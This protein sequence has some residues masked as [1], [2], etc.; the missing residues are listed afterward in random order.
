MNNL[1]NYKN[2]GMGYV[3]EVLNG[4][5]YK[6]GGVCNHQCWSETMVLQPA[7]EGM[8]GLKPDAVNN[9]ITIA[10]TFPVNWD[11]VQVKNIKCGSKILAFTMKRENG[12]TVWNFTN[13]NGKQK[14]L[15]KTIFPAGTNI[16]NTY[17][18][19]KKTIPAVYD[20][21]RKTVLSLEANISN[22]LTIEI[23]HQGGIA[24]LPIITEPKPFATSDGFRIVDSKL[25]NNTFYLDVEGKPLTSH[26][27][28][29]YLP[30][31]S[32]SNVENGKV[33]S[34][35]GL[36]TTIQ[37]D[38]EESKEKYLYKQVKVFF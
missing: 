16:I 15:F 30:N 35:D 26:Q 32:I 5:D 21:N 36:Y 27:I 8:L 6:P 29:V 34:I 7:I 38:F 28:I 19:G 23:E 2:F 33:I 9:T 10:P 24:V 25:Q 12:K 13:R 17:I 31:G 4:L 18:G 3:D 1:L 11:S 14:I 20:D 37:V 22:N